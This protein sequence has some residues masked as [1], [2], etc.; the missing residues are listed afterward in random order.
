MSRLRIHFLGAVETVTG[1]KF[2]VETEKFNIMIDCGLFQGVKKLRKKNWE[3]LPVDVSSIDNVILTHGHLDHTGFLPRLLNMGFK[4]E[5]IGTEPTLDIAEVILKDSAKIQEEQAERANLEGYSKH[6][7]AKPLYTVN[8][9]NKTVRYFK[10]IEP[11]CWNNLSDS[12]RFRLRYAG[13]I[14]GATFVELQIGEKL[15]VFSGD[16]GRSHDILMRAPKKPRKADILF[17]ESTYGNRLHPKESIEKK[18]IRLIN[19]TVDKGGTFIIPSFAVERAQNLMLQLWRMQ[20]AEKIPKIPLIL[21]SPMGADVLQI[22][23]K[24]RQWHNLQI[25]E[26]EPMCSSFKVNK[27]FK[28]T[29]ETIHDKNPK[30]VI[31]GSGMVSGGRVL[32]YLEHYIDKPETTVLLAGY[33]AEGTRGRMLL[34]NATEIKLFGN[35]HTVKA[36]V[37][38]INALSSHADQHDLLNWISDIDSA[39]EQV[40]IIHGERAASDA[41]RAKIKD[42]YGWEATIPDLNQIV[43]YLL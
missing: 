37:E 35:Y 42:T 1:S 31:A 29:L 41:L 19:E 17:I 40:F 8:D 25:D 2:L 28:S 43:D 15:L 22:F 36:R 23:K 24:Y 4:G 12:V 30:V 33:Q 34:E 26:C 18:L 13:H 27:D 20:N 38:H 16:L 3:H 5:I 11:E 7:P 39:P 9:V 14:I 10:A 6:Q 32:N 21:D